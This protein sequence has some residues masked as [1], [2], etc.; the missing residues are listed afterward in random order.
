[1]EK[2]KRCLLLLLI[3]ALVYDDLY[4][5]E[6]H[7]EEKQEIENRD[8]IE[9]FEK[10]K[11]QYQ[12]Q[13]K[14]STQLTALHQQIYDLIDQENQLI[15]NI[16]DLDQKLTLSYQQREKQKQKILVLK[17]KL[18]HYLSAYQGLKKEELLE[19]ILL[20]KNINELV[21]KEFYL[22]SLFEKELALYREIKKNEQEQND[23]IATLEN[24][25]KDQKEQEKSLELKKKALLEARRKEMIL[26]D[27]NPNETQ[28]IQGILP[29]L[30][31]KW[32]KAFLGDQN[33]GIYIQAQA[34]NIDVHSILDGE[35]LLVQR[36][37][38]RLQYSIVIK[39]AGSI[40]S[41]YAHLDEVLVKVGEK[42]KLQQTI[43]KLNPQQ[44]KLY[45]ELRKAWIPI[46][47]HQM[48]IET[49][50]HQDQK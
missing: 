6:E 27:L 1:M 14:L 9:Q 23:Q 19:H 8:E 48:I 2:I 44:S 12:A 39:H 32:Q 38:H 4:A 10:I 26:L 49:L 29:P 30:T 18:A 46:Y 17:Q 5:Q 43:G 45:F 40:Q 16:K 13:L 25:F 24:L 7:E 35:V 21:R 37:N 31:G 3:L 36:L 41:I 34:K 20:S 28:S 22:M 47:P 15:F 33:H 50:I 42:V 11:A